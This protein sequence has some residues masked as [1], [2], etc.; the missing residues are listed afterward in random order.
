MVAVAGGGGDGDGVPWSGAGFDCPAGRFF[1]VV[2][3]FA[4]SG[5]V[6]AAGGA[7]M[8]PG[9]DVV[10]VADRG[11]AVRGAAGVVA[12]WMKRRSPGGKSRA[13]LLTEPSPAPDC[14]P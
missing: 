12:V 4:K 9:D 11:V 10:Q 13:A 6:V 1:G 2:A 3:G 5:A 14:R 7:S 8:V